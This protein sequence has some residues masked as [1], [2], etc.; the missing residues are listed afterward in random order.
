MTSFEQ[1]REAILQSVEPAGVER[2]QLLDAA[3]RVIA[4]DFLA[5]WDLPRL[6]KSAMDGFAVRSAD[7]APD[8]TLSVTD[9]I[10][11]GSLPH[12]PVAAG[13]AAR[14][15]TGAPIPPDADAVIPL[16]ETDAPHGAKPTPGQTWEMG[17]VT[18]R[19]TVQSGAHIRSKG[20]EVAAGERIIGKG[21]L[22][23][24]Q[25]IGLLASFG[26]A[27][28]PVYR[29]PRVAI[30]ST[31]DELVELGTAPKG[32]EIFNSN[33]FSLAAAVQL[34]GA[35]PVLVGIAR[36]NSESHRALLSEG[37]QADVLIT[38]A[39][40]S[41]GDRDLVRET[42]ATLGVEERFWKVAIRPGGGTA[43]GVK[44]KVPVFSLP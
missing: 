44:G 15:M 35:K 39:G 1:A 42:L 43:F 33:S 10:P 2:V 40:V 27:M 23:G 8:V 12:G 17:T 11:A 20:S 31:G 41:A 30:V 6:D 32:N 26:R 19:N 37:L 14:I 5:P 16:E 36:D 22:L 3:G 18:L 34:C 28:V 7:C 29:K 13:C 4:A 25:E 21:A 9:Y 38:S 24:P